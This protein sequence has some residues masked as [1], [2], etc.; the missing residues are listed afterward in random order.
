MAT[1]SSKGLNLR[2]VDRVDEIV[3][4][5]RHDNG[6]DVSVLVGDLDLTDIG[7]F[8]AGAEILHAAMGARA[9][10]AVLVVVAPGQRQVEIVTGEQARRRVPDRVCALAVLSM[11]AAFTGGDLPGGIVEGVR[12]IAKAA[13]PGDPLPE[14]EEQQ[15]R[16]SAHGAPALHGD[17]APELESAEH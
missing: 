12:Q 3:R 16:A 10:G 2:G 9:P 4:R 15:S 6:L 14:L 13:G 17:H 8:R 1:G 7:N 5:V 11:T